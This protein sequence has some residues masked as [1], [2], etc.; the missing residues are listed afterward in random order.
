MAEEGIDIA[1]HRAKPLDVYL[2]EPFDYVVTMC[3]DTQE[4]CPIFPG[5]IIP[6]G[7]KYIHHAFDDPL[8]DAGPEC[9]R[10]ASFRRVRDE[11]REWIDLTFRSF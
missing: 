7:I 8:S 1:S 10:C 4:R 6:G 3:A 5:A 9:A 2:D 11:I